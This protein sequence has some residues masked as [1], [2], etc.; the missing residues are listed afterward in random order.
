MIIGSR[1]NLKPGKLIWVLSLLQFFSPAFVEASA[2]KNS[3]A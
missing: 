3:R 1:D 2:A